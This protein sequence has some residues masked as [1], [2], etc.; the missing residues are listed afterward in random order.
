LRRI[1]QTLACLTTQ[2]NVVVALVGAV[3]ARIHVQFIRFLEKFK[4]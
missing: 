2:A 1:A 3:A 4:N